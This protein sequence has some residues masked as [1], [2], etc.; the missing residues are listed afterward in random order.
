LKSRSVVGRFPIEG[1]ALAKGCAMFCL[2]VVALAADPVR[3]ALPPVADPSTRQAIASPTK[4]EA[5]DWVALLAKLAWEAT[6]N[7]IPQRRMAAVEQLGR[8]PADQRQTTA[9]L[10]TVRAFDPDPNVKYAADRVLT[11]L[12]W[13][14]R[15]LQHVQDARRPALGV[16]FDNRPYRDAL[17]GLDRDGISA[18]AATPVAQSTNPPAEEAVQPATAV[19]PEPTPAVEPI[20]IAE[21]VPI[22]PKEVDPPTASP[23]VTQQQLVEKVESAQRGEAHSALPTRTTAPTDAKA[24]KRESDEWLRYG[25]EHVKAGRIAEA[26]A[27]LEYVKALN[28]SYGMFEYRPATLAKEIARAKS[29]AKAK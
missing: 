21:P 25:R 22:E 7:P 20:K 5:E 14:N 13:E 1:I 17:Y 3:V 27:V 18:P 4:P 28:A 8:I 15:R 12:L 9:I 10:S 19:Q 2:L 24:R 16:A 11:Q 6:R 23:L 26:D 29:T